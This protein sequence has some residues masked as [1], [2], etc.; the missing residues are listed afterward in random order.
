MLYFTNEKQKLDQSGKAEKEI[1][2][3]MNPKVWNNICCKDK[4]KCNWN[5]QVRLV[6][7]SS[8]EGKIVLVVLL[9]NKPLYIV[10]YKQLIVTAYYHSLMIKDVGQFTSFAYSIFI[11][12]NDDFLKLYYCT[13]KYTI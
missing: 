8:E 9:Q 7:E 10:I 5:L 2:L 1:L 11:I 4:Q 12:I 3:K 13:Y 6:G